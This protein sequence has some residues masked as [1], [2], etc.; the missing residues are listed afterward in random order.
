MRNLRVVSLIWLMT[1]PKTSDE[2]LQ[3]KLDGL[4]QDNPVHPVEQG[5]ANLLA[6][7][8]KLATEEAAKNRTAGPKLS[9]SPKA[10]YLEWRAKPPMD[11]RPRGSGPA[12]PRRGWNGGQHVSH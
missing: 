11:P 12:Y 3:Q 8:K 7:L 2:E 9:A 6:G 4:W 10:I 1:G 5:Y